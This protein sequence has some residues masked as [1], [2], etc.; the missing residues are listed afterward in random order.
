M[1]HASNKSDKSEGKSEKLSKTEEACNTNLTAD[2]EE[3]LEEFCKISVDMF[4]QPLQMY[5]PDEY[6]PIVRLP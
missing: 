4:L 3:R 1:S 5:R 6:R 2:L